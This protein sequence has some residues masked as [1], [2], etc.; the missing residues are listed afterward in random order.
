MCHLVV[1][2]WRDYV[3]MA[4]CGQY[5]EAKL[6]PPWRTQHVSS[7]SANNDDDY[8]ES[9]PRSTT[10]SSQPQRTKL[11]LVRK[12]PDKPQRNPTAAVYECETRKRNNKRAAVW[13]AYQ[14]EDNDAIIDHIHKKN[15]GALPDSATLH[16]IWQG[17]VYEILYDKVTQELKQVNT[18]NGST[19]RVRRRPE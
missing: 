16:I 9:N 10:A 11:T 12:I 19:R 13:V 5:S 2:Q 6:S 17:V 8:S 14:N 4:A 1:Q 3:V 7:P 18:D 15:I